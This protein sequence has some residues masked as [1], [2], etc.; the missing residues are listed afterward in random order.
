MYIF[1]VHLLFFSVWK[2]HRKII[3]NLGERN[4]PVRVRPIEKLFLT[5]NRQKTFYFCVYFF[6]STPLEKYFSDGICIFLCVFA[7][8]EEFEFPAVIQ[9]RVGDKLARPNPI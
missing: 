5:A 6:V 2:S 9:K 3:F 1:F 7:H 4:F 8:R